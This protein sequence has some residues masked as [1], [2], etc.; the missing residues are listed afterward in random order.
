MPMIDQMWRET[1]EPSLLHELVQARDREERVCVL[2]R[3]LVV[4]EVPSL[5]NS[6]STGVLNGIV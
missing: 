3:G 6:Q 1:A 5:L 2:E 4:V